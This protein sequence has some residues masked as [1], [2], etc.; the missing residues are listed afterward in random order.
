MLTT[1]FNVA[2]LVGLMIPGYIIGKKK[3]IGEGGLKALTVVLVYVAQ[4][5][6]IIAAFQNN[7]YEPYM[8]AGMGWTVL[9]SFGVLILG[10]L[11]ALLIFRIVR[12]DRDY[13]NS[14]RVYAL[15]SVI[16]NSGFMGIPVIKAMLP[17]NTEALVYS[18][19][20]IVIFNVVI[21]T[22]GVYVITGN[23]QYISLKKAIFNPPTLALFVALP[24]FFARIAL[25]DWL[26]NGVNMLGDMPTPLCMIILGIKLSQIKFVELFNRSGVY[27]AVLCKLFVIPLFT[28]L[29]VYFLPID[30]TVRATVYLSMC[31]PSASMVLVFCEM[32]GGDGYAASKTQLL[33]TVLSVLSI[34]LL[35]LLL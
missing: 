6:M 32:F 35:G 1:F 14:S 4:P 15:S 5:F 17:G 26:M 11:L 29:C 34:P 21:W 9:L 33:S 16:S 30:G 13:E 3:M 10:V 28:Y 2:V 8:L 27:L 7:A 23:K 22:V 25:P 24:L 12:T 20:F 18:A 31:M 19:V